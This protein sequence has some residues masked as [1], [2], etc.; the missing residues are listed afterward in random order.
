MFSKILNPC[1]Q[2]SSHCTHKV[3]KGGKNLKTS[4][5]QKVVEPLSKPTLRRLVERMG[6]VL[7]KHTY[8]TEDG[9]INTVFR[10]PAEKGCHGTLGKKASELAPK[11]VAVY[12]H[13]IIDSCVGIVCGEE[14]SLGIQLVEAGF[15]L[16]L[17]NSR[18]N[19]YSQDH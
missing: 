2:I 17:A 18:G 15:D 3:K 19:R 16:W 8:N 11:P 5:K 10:I 7:E 1:K 14:N 13:G 9:Y 12:Q 6:Y 4:F